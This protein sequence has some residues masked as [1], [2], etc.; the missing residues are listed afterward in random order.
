[1][2]VPKSRFTLFFVLLLVGSL[3]GGHVGATTWLQSKQGDQHTIHYAKEY[4][5]DLEFFRKWMDFAFG[6]AKDKYGLTETLC[7]TDPDT[8]GGAVRRGGFGC[9]YSDAWPGAGDHGRRSFR[10]RASLRRVRVRTRIGSDS[11]WES[12]G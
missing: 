8:L 5:D 9:S 12:V 10:R 6:V 2:Y 7:P 4:E 1:M 3:A 11:N